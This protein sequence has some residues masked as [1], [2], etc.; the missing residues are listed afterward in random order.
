[1]T[2]ALLGHGTLF[3]TLVGDDWVTAAEVRDISPPAIARDSIDIS[4]EEAPGE[5]GTAMPGTRRGGEMSFD[6]N[7]IPGGAVFG[8]L[9]D[10]LGDDTV[11][12]RRL[13]FPN[14]FAFPFSGFLITLEPKAG[15]ADVM[16][17][18]ATLKLS[19]APGPMQWVGR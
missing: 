16:T 17:A 3:Q 9:Y 7:F 2:D 10:E 14:G 19:G 11:R 5:W 18:A 12:Q 8:D 6:F 1:M 13:L 4:D 15:M